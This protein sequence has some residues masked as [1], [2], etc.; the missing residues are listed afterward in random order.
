MKI[1]EKGYEYI[2]KKYLIAVKTISDMYNWTAK[3]ILKNPFIVYT[4]NVK[5]LIIKILGAVVGNLINPIPKKSTL[6]PYFV[7]SHPQLYSTKI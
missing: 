7:Q 4:K 1:K 2:P 6:L 3:K 5:P